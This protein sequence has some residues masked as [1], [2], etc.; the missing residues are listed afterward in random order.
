MTVSRLS[1][2]LATCLI[3]GT[4]LVAL[5]ISPDALAALEYSAALL[6]GARANDIEVDAA[7][8]IYLGGTICEDGTLPVTSTAAQPTRSGGC[9]GFVAILGPDR[10]LQHATYIGGALQERIPGIAVDPQGNVYVPGDTTSPDFPT[11]NLLW[12]RTPQIDSV[13][14]L[15][16]CLSGSQFPCPVRC[17]VNFDV[18]LT[19]CEFHRLGR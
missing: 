3:A 7:G 19:T 8:R 6:P 12:W 2:L 18:R 17:I 1:P 10:R 14:R 13:I 5:Q 9:D 16:R 15:H 11:T 4:L